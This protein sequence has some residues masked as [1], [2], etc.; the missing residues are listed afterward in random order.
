MLLTLPPPFNC[1]GT[2]VNMGSRFFIVHPEDTG[3]R[4]LQRGSNYSGSTDTTYKHI[5][6]GNI[7]TNSTL[8]NWMCF[9][10]QV[11]KGQKNWRT[12][13]VRVVSPE[14]NEG[15]EPT[16]R[17]AWSIMICLKRKY[18]LILVY[19][20]AYLLSLRYNVSYT[21]NM[22]NAVWT[23]SKCIIQQRYFV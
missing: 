8:A 22:I 17:W 2:V 20:Y 3:H 11:W 18:R 7:T 21:N 14:L 5:W 16:S 15:M 13:Y 4:Q 1:H 12:R 9:L 23:Y 19:W 6:P 10:L